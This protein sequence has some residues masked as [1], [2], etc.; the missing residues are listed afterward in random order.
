MGVQGEPPR[1]G[2]QQ[3]CVSY[4][5]AGK[6]NRERAATTREQADGNGWRKGRGHEV[7]TCE[8]EKLGDAAGTVRTEDRQAGSA[9]CK[10]QGKR[11]EG[12]DAGQEAGRAEE[13]RTAAW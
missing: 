6:E 8:A 4:S 1:A 10:V 13:P 3:D 11:G 9:F 7:A 2:E 12:C 5:G